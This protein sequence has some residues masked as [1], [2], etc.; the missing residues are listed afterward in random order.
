MYVQDNTT[1]ET[2]FK[3]EDYAG[4]HNGWDQNRLHP[5]KHSIVI[6]KRD[7][8]KFSVLVAQLVLFVEY[9]AQ[10]PNMGSALD[11]VAKAI[12]QKKVA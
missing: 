6:E 9:A 7:G 11:A 1:R 3:M 4:V 12:P 5:M 2:T 8:T 10:H